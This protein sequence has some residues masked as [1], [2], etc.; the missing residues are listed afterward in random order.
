MK[1]E[2]PTEVKAEESFFQPVCITPT[3]KVFPGES[4]AVN[5][6]SRWEITPEEKLLLENSAQLQAAC[7]EFERV[8]E[9]LSSHTEMVP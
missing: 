1:L 6:G 2:D 5:E 4:R 3:T 9:F 7:V 8:L